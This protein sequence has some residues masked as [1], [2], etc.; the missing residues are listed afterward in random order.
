MSYKHLTKDDRIK[1][2]TLVDANYS[3]NYIAT[4][5]GC[6]PSTISR[7]INRSVVDSSEDEKYKYSQANNLAIKK[8]NEANGLRA[9]LTGVNQNQELLKYLEDK[10]K[11]SWSPEQIVGRIKLEGL[12]FG[13][14][15]SDGSSV[16]G[17]RGVNHSDVSIT[18][19]SHQTIYDYVHN[20][21][22]DLVKY[23][24]CKKGKYRRRYGTRIREKEREA[25]E[26]KR[27]EQ[28][29]RIIEERTR[30]GDFE[31]DTIVGK[32]KTHMLT[33]VDRTSGY[34]LANILSEATASKTQEVTIQT[35]SKL[36][37]NKFQTITY[38]NG[39]QFAKH[40]D[41]EQKLGIDIYFA[42][43]YH[44]WERGTNENTN[45]LLREYYPKG[46]NFSSITQIDL[47]KTV[48]IINNRPRKRHNY[49]TP[50]EIWNKPQLK[51]QSI[52]LR[53]GM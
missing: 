46:S 48:K 21:R 4:V 7:E 36:P 1:I 52:A 27:I 8:R 45:G 50:Q 17:A 25:M 42:T 34:L 51:L 19:K 2:Q 11:K 9:K 35:F 32:D 44:S 49:H 47:D 13:G 31:G 3:N 12:S 39:V 24:R 18:L 16:K 20:N 6:N 43:P 22:P 38:D 30:L 41:T 28:R 37:K 10:L 33:H 26:K 15:G 5:I 14:G 23:L 53:D 29:P 40:Q